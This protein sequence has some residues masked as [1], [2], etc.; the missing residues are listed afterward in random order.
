MSLQKQH[1]GELSLAKLL[2][3][4]TATL[5]KP[6]YV[7]C[8]IKDELKLPPFSEVEMLFRE[9][10]S[11]GITVITTRDY[12]ESHDLEWAFPCKKITLDVTSSLEAVGF[13]AVIATRLAKEGMGVNP[14]S[15][16]YH[17]H[18]FVPEGRESDAMMILSEIAKEKQKETLS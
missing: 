12:A 8:V 17:D 7:F 11:E 15:G 9:S 3:T 13:I 10:S 14:I 2:A 6:T 18:L 16:F 1:P 5:H 4:L